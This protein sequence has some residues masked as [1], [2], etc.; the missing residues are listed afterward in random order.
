MDDI[1]ATHHD[2]EEIW[3][4]EIDNADIYF[5]N[6]H[7]VTHTS[8]KNSEKPLPEFLVGVEIDCS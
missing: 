7:T 4:D 3:F 1:Y 2:Y 6:V 8:F 5:S